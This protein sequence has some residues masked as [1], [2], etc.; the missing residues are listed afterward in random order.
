MSWFHSRR[1]SLSLALSFVRSSYSRMHTMEHRKWCS[2][3][4]TQ[5][6]AWM[7]NYDERCEWSGG[8]PCLG[9]F[10]DFRNICHIVQLSFFIVADKWRKCTEAHTHTHTGNGRK[11]VRADE[12]GGRTHRK[13]QYG[14]RKVI[15]CTTTQTGGTMKLLVFLSLATLAQCRK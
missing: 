8:L 5:C 4:T 9:G 12:G 7:Q 15:V 10:S 13:R 11:S 1:S 6:A 14:R 3:R 2:R